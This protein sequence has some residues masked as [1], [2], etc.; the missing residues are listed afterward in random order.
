MRLVVGIMGFLWGFAVGPFRLFGA[1]TGV[2]RA[3]KH[4]LFQLRTV[5]K[6]KMSRALIV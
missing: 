6:K 3:A 5:E 2:P 4:R 1:T